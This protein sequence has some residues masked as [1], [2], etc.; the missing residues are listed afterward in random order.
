[1]IFEDEVVDA[2]RAEVAIVTKC[3]ATDPTGLSETARTI[4]GDIGV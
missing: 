2:G 4:A 1:M 3:G